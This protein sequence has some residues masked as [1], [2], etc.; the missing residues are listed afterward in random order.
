MKTPALDRDKHARSVAPVPNARAE[1]K[2]ASALLAFA[3]RKGDPT[4]K[5]R[6]YPLVLVLDGR[7]FDATFATDGY[8]MALRV[9]G[10]ASDLS[11]VD[12]PSD[13]L[14]VEP[15]FGARDDDRP[16]AYWLAFRHLSDEPSRRIGLDAALLAR[17]DDVQQALRVESRA[18]LLELAKDA[19]RRRDRKAAEV[20][21]K[22]ASETS[23][24]AEWRVSHAYDP[25]LWVVR[26]EPQNRIHVPTLY[27]GAIMPW[28]M[29]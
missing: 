8:S 16:P 17:V 13:F 14:P 20:W 10:D 1:E 5:V 3:K 9:R 25:V 12:D 21:E 7:R 23:P 26:V 22:A 28:S 15:T 18:R 19:Q 27:V 4:W 24:R 2:S 29:P 11:C 6:T